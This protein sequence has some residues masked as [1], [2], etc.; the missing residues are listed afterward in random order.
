MKPHNGEGANRQGGAA[1]PRRLRPWASF[2]VH[3]A[4][5]TS[6]PLRLPPRWRHKIEVCYWVTNFDVSI[7]ML[8]KSCPRSSSLNLRRV[9]STRT[10]NSAW[11][12]L[13]GNT[14]EDGAQIQVPI[15]TEELEWW[16]T[17]CCL[18]RSTYVVGEACESW[19]MEPW[20]WKLPFRH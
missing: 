19:L 15:P 14:W 10:T 1:M 9:S 5:Q 17:N 2:G 18:L 3:N 6:N 20:Y 8:S 4:W 13:L 7:P 12:K 11:N 16:Q